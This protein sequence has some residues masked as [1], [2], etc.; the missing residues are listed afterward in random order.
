MEYIS[1]GG[2]V[3]PG[4]AAG[5]KRF[6]S[7][8]PLLSDTKSSSRP[9]IDT[10]PWKTAILN[11]VLSVTTTTLGPASELVKVEISKRNV[12]LH[13]MGKDTLLGSCLRVP[14]KG[15]VVD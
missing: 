9:D 3:V 14:S 2:W 6:L 4:I 15:I 5:I 13:V 8:I 11:N 12:N 1:A 10:S 7:V